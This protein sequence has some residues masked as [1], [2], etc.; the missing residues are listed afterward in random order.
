MLNILI[1]GQQEVAELLTDE[2]SVEK[3][4]SIIELISS[5]AYLPLKQHQKLMPIL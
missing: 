3:T 2:E 5:G 4:L 1:Q